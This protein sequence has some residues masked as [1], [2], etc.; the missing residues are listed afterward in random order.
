MKKLLS[1]LFLLSV[2]YEHSTAQQFYGHTATDVNGKNINI[3]R[4]KGKKLM[5]IF[6]SADKVNSIADTLAA[7]RDQYKDLVE[8]I[9]II[10]PSKKNMG[11]S[12]VTM[13][14]AAQIQKKKH[15]L[16]LNGGSDEA[17][18]PLLKWLSNQDNTHSLIKDMWVHGCKILIGETGRVMN[19]FTDKTSLDAPIIYWALKSTPYK[20]TSR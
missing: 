20:E 7:F 11:K 5:I 2:L 9:G 13:N 6:I 3:N 15:L 16:L 10:L 4:F 19:V 18:S 8:V 12:S 14:S 1:I 17:V